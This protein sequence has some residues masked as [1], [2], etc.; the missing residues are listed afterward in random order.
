MTTTDMIAPVAPIAPSPFRTA[1][2]T[3]AL[4]NWGLVA[5]LLLI[6]ATTALFAGSRALWI[7]LGAVLGSFCGSAGGAALVAPAFRRG[8]PAWNALL[9]VL[10]AAGAI[11][12]ASTAVYALNGWL[13]PVIESDAPA[14]ADSGIHPLSFALLFGPWNLPCLA[15]GIGCGI[16]IG[17]R[18]DAHAT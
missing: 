13:P 11:A 5:G 12:A 15:L 18:L 8:R 10:I 1:A 6:T 16:H 3:A 7:G 17:R 4:W 9:G 2:R 14:G